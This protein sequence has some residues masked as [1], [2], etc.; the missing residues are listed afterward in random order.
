MCCHSMSVSSVFPAIPVTSLHLR[1]SLSLSLR[2]RTDFKSFEPCWL[3]LA[4]QLFLN[5]GCNIDAATAATLHQQ[6]VKALGGSYSIGAPAVA[7]GGK[8]WLQVRN[9]SPS[10]IMRYIEAPFIF[11][12]LS[13]HLPRPSQCHIV[14]IL[15]IPTQ[16]PFPLG[17]CSNPD[18][19]LTE[20]VT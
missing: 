18:I 5:G 16:T 7:W 1:V 11:W 15:H 20:F 17:P 19:K 2:K 14:L 8:P 6:W 10:L 4:D 12:F 9:P 3:S 13:P